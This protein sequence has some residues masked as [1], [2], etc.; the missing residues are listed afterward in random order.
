MI[1][2]AKTLTI[3]YYYFGKNFNV[4]YVMSTSLCVYT[5]EKN[6]MLVGDD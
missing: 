4:F 1:C 6:D 3:I 5:Q 2:L